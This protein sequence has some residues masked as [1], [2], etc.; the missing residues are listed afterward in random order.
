VAGG[1]A[2]A[3]QVPD[4]VA[5]AGVI[6]A[7][8]GF[9][10]ERGARGVRA[11]RVRKQLGA[12]GMLL[13][14]GRAVAQTMGQG[15]RASVVV[16]PDPDGSWV[17]RLQGQS[18]DASRLFGESV[19]QILLPVD[20]PRY[21]VSRRLGTGRAI[22]WHAVP[23]AFGVNKTSAAAFAEQWRVFVSRGELLYTGSAE[24]AAVAQTVRGLDPMDLTTAMYAEWG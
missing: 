17:L 22:M 10:I 21:I 20:F 2:V 16:Q 7:G 15:L 5:V 14:F 19:E 8:A 1:L 11:R 24:G 18:A 4:L 13:A 9:A 12:D 3:G 6:G 23:D